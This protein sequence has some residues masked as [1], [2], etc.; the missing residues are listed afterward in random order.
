MFSDT[1]SPFDQWKNNSTQRQKLHFALSR[2]KGE[3]VNTKQIA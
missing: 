3:G 1:W 2:D